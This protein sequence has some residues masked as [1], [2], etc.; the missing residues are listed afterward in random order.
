MA[1]YLA[2]QAVGDEQTTVTLDV[3]VL[4]V[5]EQ[6]TATADHHQQTT[7]SVVV[8]LVM[9]E[10]LVE[11]VD[12]G[13]QDGNLDFGR[14]AVCFVL[15]VGSDRRG[16]VDSDTVAHGWCSFPT[17]IAMTAVHGHLKRGDHLPARGRR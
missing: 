11:V 15:T 1:G 8:M 13:S 9:L 6:A 12:A 4:H 10:V 2:T 17:R 14:T 3:E 5:V 7:A 16:L